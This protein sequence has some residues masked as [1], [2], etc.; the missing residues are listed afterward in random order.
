MTGVLYDLR[1]ATTELA[2][3]FDG[4][5]TQ[6]GV[7]QTIEKVAEKLCK[8]VRVALGKDPGF[9]DLRVSEEGAEVFIDDV[10]VGTTPLDKQKILG[11][12]H[13][14]QVKKEEFLVFGQD[15]LVE[16]DKTVELDV[17]LLR[18]SE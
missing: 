17:T 18:S 5:C 2:A 1:K 9:L 6:E 10:L 12:Y 4:P 15:V 13:K 16:P 14:V 11:G 7:F 8:P 3:T